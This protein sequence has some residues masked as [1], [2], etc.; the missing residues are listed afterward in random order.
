MAS[1]EKI[2][3]GKKRAFNYFLLKKEIPAMI[4]GMYLKAKKMKRPFKQVVH[5]YLQ[6]YVDENH[7][8]PN[9][10]QKIINTW[11]TYLPKLGIRQEL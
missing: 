5:D 4:S 8:T 3:T 1:R 7:I 9:E 2:Q 10:Y 6:Y 11:K